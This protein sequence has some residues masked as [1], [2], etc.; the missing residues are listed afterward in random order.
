MPRDGAGVEQE[1]GIT[2]GQ[3]EMFHGDGYAHY[4]DCGNGFTVVYICQNVLNCTL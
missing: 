3:V 4:L 1:R 2:K